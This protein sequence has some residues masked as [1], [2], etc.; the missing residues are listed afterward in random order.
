MF[1]LSL[2]HFG[3]ANIHHSVN[4]IEHCGPEKK[5]SCCLFLFTCTTNVE[6]ILLDWNVCTI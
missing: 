4:I 6:I 2:I 3:P 1:M 5:C